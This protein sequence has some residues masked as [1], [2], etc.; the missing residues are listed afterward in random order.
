MFKF[1][2]WFMPEGETHLPDWMTKTNNRVDGRLAYQYTKYEQALKWCKNR[3]VAI[4]IGAHIGL[5]SWYMARD[6][7]DL[8]AFEPMQEHQ[9]CWVLNMADR[10]N[11]ELFCMALG[12]YK[13]FVHLH[14]RT[15][16]SSG[17]TEIYPNADGKTEIGRLDD[18]NLPEVDFIKIDCEGYELN[19]LQGA[20]KT[21]LA[22]KPCI[23]VEQK[24]DMTKKYGH[25]KLAAVK[26]LESLGAKLRQEISGDYIMSWDEAGEGRQGVDLA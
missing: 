12:N 26:Y 21:L 19:V 3:R 16:G 22:W 14:C 15:K 11:A 7:R 1:D 20:E 5:W 13:G 4:D 9:D 8:A 17:D 24:G 25:E 23:V 10:K 18:A 2:K 6:F